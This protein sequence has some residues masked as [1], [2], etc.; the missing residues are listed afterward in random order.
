VYPLA[1]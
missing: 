1:D